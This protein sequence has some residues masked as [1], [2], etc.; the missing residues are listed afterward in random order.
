MANQFS[1]RKANCEI[2]S[3]SNASTYVLIN[4]LALTSS[5][6]AKS[7]WEQECAAWL[8]GHDQHTFFWGV[9]GFDVDDIAW[10]RHSFTSQ[11]AFV[12]RVIDDL[13]TRQWYK[14][15][16]M[17]RYNL[18]YFGRQVRELRALVD[19]Y[20]EEFVEPEKTWEWPV[21]PEALSMCRIH[22]VYRH[23]LG[24]V[25]CND[26]VPATHGFRRVR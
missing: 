7:F 10:D 4:M 21:V 3:L 16:K 14:R 20:E 19:A 11:K 17:L 26:R 9:V 6:R 23:E 8:A 24:C 22:R 5:A 1:N 15:W 13:F 18:M 12:L 2:V 25:L